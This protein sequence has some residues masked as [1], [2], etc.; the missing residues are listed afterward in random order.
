[1]PDNTVV[2]SR[3]RGSPDWGN[4]YRVGIDGTAEECVR[5]FEWMWLM[6]DAETIRTMTTP[7]RGKNL[8]CWCKLDAPC[9]ADVLLRLANNESSA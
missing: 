6:S 2:V 5:K 9:H 4:P 1:M 3:R 7:L 8:A